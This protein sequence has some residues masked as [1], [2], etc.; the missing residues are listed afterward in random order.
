MVEL[1]MCLNTIQLPNCIIKVIISFYSFIAPDVTNI[2]RDLRVGVFDLQ[3]LQVKISFP[4][5]S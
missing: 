3:P 1:K 4:V 5:S 2:N